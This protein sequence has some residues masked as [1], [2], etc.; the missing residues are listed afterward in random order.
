MGSPC[1]FRID[2]IFFNRVMKVSRMINIF[3]IGRPDTGA[4]LEQTLVTFGE[5]G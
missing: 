1:A 4:V 2:G 5:I 3:V